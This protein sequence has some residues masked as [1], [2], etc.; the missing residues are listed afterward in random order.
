MV[1]A[2]AKGVAQDAHRVRKITKGL[3]EHES[4]HEWLLDFLSG[5][6]PDSSSSESD[7]SYSEDSS[8]DR[9]TETRAADFRPGGY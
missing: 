4:L 2:R 6:A 3:V 8:N 5:E 7:T 9:T 1:R